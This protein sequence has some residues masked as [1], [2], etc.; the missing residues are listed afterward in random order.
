MRLHV[1]SFSMLTI[2][3]LSASADMISPEVQRAQERLQANPNV[4]DRVDD[5]C[6][7]KKPGAVCSIPG[8]TFAGGGEGICKN[9]FNPWKSTIDLSCVRKGEVWIDRKLPEGGFVN[10]S[11]LCAREKDE[12]CGFGKKIPGGPECPSRW[13][14]KPMNPT[15][16][17]QFCKNKNVGSSCTVE[18]IYQGKTERHDGICS[19]IVETERFYY[20]GHRE[21][22][23]NVIRCEPPPVAPRNF[24]PVS[25]HKKLIP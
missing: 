2:C 13:N 1:I 8:N 20:Q 21:A 16:A 17:D 14:C 4:Y 5:Y 23:R 11:N 22:T 10:D 19:M 25:W 24:S 6:K 3:C 15:P 7:D 9:A 12:D 18:L